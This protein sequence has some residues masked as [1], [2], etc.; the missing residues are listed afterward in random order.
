MLKEFLVDSKPTSLMLN[1]IVKLVKLYYVVPVTT[2]T[3]ERS[4]S[5]LRRLKTFLR[6]TMGQ[7]RLNHVAILNIH[8]EYVDELDIKLLVNDFIKKNTQ[9]RQVFALF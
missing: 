6:T 8:K 7:A 1:E 4:F 2:C 5:L 9:R 3:A